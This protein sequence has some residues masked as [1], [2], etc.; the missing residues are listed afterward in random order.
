[1]KRAALIIAWLL[2]AAARGVACELCAIYNAN[3]ANGQ[4]NSG[5]TL[6]I[7][8]LFVPYRTTQLD[9]HQIDLP[10]PNYLDSS[11]THLV[12]TYNF[13]EHL[14]LSL[15]LPIVYNSFERT[16]LIYFPPGPIPFG[17]SKLVTEKGQ[18]WGPGDLALIGRWTPFQRSTMRW[19]FSINLLGGIKLPTGDSSRLEDEV[20]QDQIFIRYFLPPG[21]PHD[22]LSHSISPI[23]QHDL[24]LGSGSVDGIFGATLNARWRRLFLSTQV[25]YYLRTEGTASFEY[26]DEFIV[27]FGP[28]AY[29]WLSE[30]YTLALKANTTYYTMA[31]DKILDQESELSG[32]NAWF[33]GPQLVF[34]WGNH[35]SA[36]TSLDLPIRIQTRGLQNVPDYRISAGISWR[37]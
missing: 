23:H 1:M 6:S 29:L 11:I 31:E 36:N 21:K 32:Q 15:N 3:G 16:D 5:L 13:T 37:F 35:F 34:T 28:G 7:E 25:Q 8:E 20:A 22:P 33:L 12:G 10:H 4:F 19:G 18:E 30:S 17:T 2:V 26:G 9:G 24:A 27:S 14:G